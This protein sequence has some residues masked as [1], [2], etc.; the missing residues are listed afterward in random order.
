M[1][2][3]WN[4]R[5]ASER[6][7]AQHAA[8]LADMQATIDSLRAELAAARADMEE[9]HAMLCA[10]QP[11]AQDDVWQPV[12]D[13]EY[14]QDD[15]NGPIVIVGNGD[16]VACPVI[17]SDDEAVLLEP[18]MAVCRLVA[19]PAVTEAD[20]EWGVR[21]AQEL[22]LMPDAQGEWTPV[23]DGSLRYHMGLQSYMLDGQPIDFFRLPENVAICHRTAPVGGQHE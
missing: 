22:G 15:P 21:K 2:D 14:L 18:G 1:S 3:I 19:A 9:M 12:P 16:T 4:Y 6:H 20:I 7:A 5:E 10:Q 11:D 17:W 23:P 13:G 8:Q